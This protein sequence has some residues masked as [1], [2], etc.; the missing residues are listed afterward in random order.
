MLDTRTHREFPSG[1]KAGARLIDHASLDA[2]LP[3]PPGA[4][5][6]LPA[7]KL[8][9]VV[10]AVPVFSTRLIEA[11][12]AVAA[13]VKGPDDADHE[14]WPIHREGFLE[15][16]DRLADHRRVVVL[17]GDVHYAFSAQV[18][19]ARGANTSCI[20]QFCSSS[21]KNQNTLGVLV[22]GASVLPGP[23]PGVLQSAWTLR[24]YVHAWVEGE[25]PLVEEDLAKASKA[26][27]TSLA[28]APERFAGDGGD[29]LRA[30][31]SSIAARPHADLGFFPV[32]VP[33]VAELLSSQLFATAKQAL[34]KAFG[35]VR[36]CLDFLT[37]PAASMDDISLSGPWASSR[38]G[39]EVELLLNRIG[40]RTIVDFN[41]IALVTFRVTD[42]EPTKA[43]QTLLWK[44]QEKTLRDPVRG[45]FLDSALEFG[46]SGGVGHTVHEASLTLP[47]PAEVG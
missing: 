35:D 46:V 30:L 41:N 14:S 16:L 47:T 4:P 24:G 5:H 12:L 45:A 39:G 13:K 22:R 27:L 1:A 10:S 32:G 40:T 20:V 19:V 26:I 23:P 38:P 44:V 18:S 37:D 29:L 8:T 34:L 31:A 25:G 9:L 42:G 7:H 43:V 11:G 17:S 33:E 21:I 15:L 28:A 3:K 2:Q 36:V 6:A